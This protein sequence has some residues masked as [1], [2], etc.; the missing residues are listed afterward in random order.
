VGQHGVD[1][2]CLDRRRGVDRDDPG[3]RMRAAQGRAPEHPVAAEVAG[4]FELPLHFGDAVHASNRLANTALAADVDTHAQIMVASLRLT[5]CPSWT[6]G[7]PSTKRC[8]TGPG[9]Q[10]TSAATGS[11]SA[12]RK[13]RPSV[14]KIAISARLPT[15]S[16]PTSS[17]PRHA[18]PPRVATRSAWRA[19]IDP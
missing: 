5:R 2:R 19:L 4:V 13:A 16:D 12:P 7:F 3:M 9:L 1:A 15:S 10:K 6:T 8:W 11:A 18:A 14:A 17:R